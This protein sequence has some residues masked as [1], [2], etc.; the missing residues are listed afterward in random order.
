M[1]L[2]SLIF[3]RTYYKYKY[4]PEYFYLHG[5]LGESL[6]WSRGSA[7]VL[8]VSCSV[9]LLPMCRNLLTFIR[10]KIPKFLGLTLKR[11]IDKHV[12]IHRACAIITVIFAAMHTGA[13]L[14]NGK[15]FSDNYN[16][17][18]PQLNFADYKNQNPLEL[19]LFSVAG[20]T[21]FAM[22]LILVVMFSASTSSV[23][24]SSYEV[25]WFTHHLFVV[26]LVLLSIHG[27][28][29][30]VKHQ[31]NL[32]MHPPGCEVRRNT[33]IATLIQKEECTEAA[34]FEADEPQAWKFLFV[35]L[36]IYLLD[37]MIRFLRK[38]E[39]VEIVKVVCHSSDVVELRMKMK[40]LEASPGQYVYISCS[41]VAKFEWHPF[42]LTKCPISE[43]DVFSVHFKITG[44]WTR[45]FSREI[46]AFREDPEKLP[47]LVQ[48][49]K[50]SYILRRSSIRICVDGPYGSPCMDVAQYE[51]SL[52]IATGIGVTPFAALLN[53][54][55]MEKLLKQRT[56]YPR[57]IYFIWVS[58]D[59]ISHRWFIDILY[60]K[61]LQLWESNCP[62][63]LA[64][65]NQ[66]T[67]S[68]WM[69]ARLTQGRPD[70]QSIFRR[71]AQENP[72]STVGVFYCGTK[73]VSS[74]LR[75][76]C[77]KSNKTKTIF[78]YNKE[79]L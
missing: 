53:N 27:F 65:E 58:R 60:S 41:R 5:M 32:S 7:A 79:I 78:V 49:D 29:G 16:E 25:F 68:S 8:W 57:R 75:K 36:C 12:W 70:W 38:F 18:Y 13:H 71:V 63:V 22:M 64:C 50:Q 31:T 9:I 74:K 20:S 67:T 76:L 14:I 6:A 69:R 44:D 52:C 42:T 73:N 17:K 46:F 37:R 48:R 26:F 33:T 28:G 19:V 15:Q 56:N 4:C 1:S 11:I 54:L 55:R 72:R 62:D 10:K 51:V 47:L 34:E 77:N 24:N 21:G 30:V 3:W 39:K 35:P 2:S 59:V 43:D 61:H 45:K 23:K 40:H 66:C